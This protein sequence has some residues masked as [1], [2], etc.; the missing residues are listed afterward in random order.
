M[1]PLKRQL[2]RTQQRNR[3]R[4]RFGHFARRDRHHADR[5]L[6]RQVNGNLAQPVIRCIQ[7]PHQPAVAHYRFALAVTGVSAAT[8]VS[9]ATGGLS[10]SAGAARHTL[11][12]PQPH[13][14]VLERLV[15]PVLRRGYHPP[16]AAVV[17]GRWA[18]LTALVHHVIEH[19]QPTGRY[20]VL[21]NP[22]ALIIRVDVLH[23]IAVHLDHPV[24][25]HA[26]GLVPH[27]GARLMRADVVQ[28]VEAGQAAG[29]FPTLP[30]S[31]SAADDHLQLVPL[32]QIGRVARPSQMLQQV[33]LVVV[34][35]DEIENFVAVGVQIAQQPAQLIPVLV[36]PIGEMVPQQHPVI[37]AVVDRAHQAAGHI[38]REAIL[39]VVLATDHVHRGVEPP[40]VFQHSRPPARIVSLP[41]P[42]RIVAR[43][44][45]QLGV[46]HVHFRWHGP[47]E[48]RSRQ[49]P[50]VHVRQVY[51]PKAVLERLYHLDATP[52]PKRPQLRLQ[53]QVV[54]A[55]LD[56]LGH[57][58]HRAGHTSARSRH[59]RMHGDLVADL[60]DQGMYQPHR[61]GPGQARRHPHQKVKRI[62]RRQDQRMA[63]RRV[64][65]YQTVLP[66]CRLSIR[67]VRRS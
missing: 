36:D 32:D 16:L 42:L 57:P 34:G 29:K 19:P 39:M 25:A 4:H 37:I 40:E 55:R 20:R 50:H 33:Q 60:P 49:V 30:V 5:A 21:S 41:A 65:D 51:E 9:G 10:A 28:P 22:V 17:L 8:A 67:I 47:I 13:P 24:V 64:Q 11:R 35:H 14:T 6:V 43:G 18:E 61:H 26:R 38:P 59:G 52:R 27:A 15:Q 54:Q 48:V 2:C 23:L 7:H 3:Q 12:H 46:Q 58:Q 63:L 1:L 31:M 45:N 44:H 66:R 56:C 53:F 62:T